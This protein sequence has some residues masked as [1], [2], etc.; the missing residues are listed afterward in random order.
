M[1]HKYSSNGA[2][3]IRKRSI[4]D[5]PGVRRIAPARESDIA[6]F[7]S[8]LCQEVFGFFSGRRMD[9]LVRNNWYGEGQLSFAGDRLAN[10]LWCGARKDMQRAAEKTITAQRVYC[11]IL[12]VPVLLV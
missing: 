10:I 1:L 8:D 6:T 7:G 9:G 2:V 12:T 5:A 3:A 11:T 4:V